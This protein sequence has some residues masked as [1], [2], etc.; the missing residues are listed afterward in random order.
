MRLKIKNNS[1]I[2]TLL[3]TMHGRK[4]KQK[5]E[6]EDP[7]ETTKRQTKVNKY[8]KLS[9]AVL[10]L[11][12]A[13]N[14][15][16]QSINDDTL[17]K[18]TETNALKATA[19]MASVNPDFYTLWNLRR[20]VLTRQLVQQENE[21]QETYSKRATQVSNFE[22]E[23]TEIALIKRNPKCYYA[24]HHRKWVI[25]LG[26][27]DLRAELE[28][29]A[30]FLERDER[31]F[32]CWTYR[33][34]VGQAL[35]ISKKEEFQFTED[36]IQRNFSNGSAWHQRTHCLSGGGNGASLTNE[37]EKLREA[38]YTEPDDQSAWMYHRW[39]LSRLLKEERSTNKNTE[40]F[41]EAFMKRLGG[42]GCNSGSSG[43]SEDVK[44]VDEQKNTIGKEIDESTI[45][46]IFETEMN[47]C[48]ELINVEP[49]CRWPRLQLVHMIDVCQ[50]A[51][52]NEKFKM[53]RIS[54][55]E[56]LLKVD[57]T[58]AKFYEYQLQ[59]KGA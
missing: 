10:K 8:T 58:H 38:I 24:W 15:L 22:L 54:L 43:S 26:Y 18:T 1:H 17:T 39:I 33:R 50:F 31:N 55:L 36:L 56:N 34:C 4:R 37:L 7:V 47:M 49:T 45:D 48:R 44:Q 2:I 5:G 19:K 29:C 9:A 41:Y 16:Y 30:R 3:Y 23:L 28:L 11:R 27:C 59:K 14:Q 21:D 12:S 51:S 25:G 20:D 32:H 40:I 53:E 6:V 42:G 13:I 35:Q 52:T 46:S 57:P